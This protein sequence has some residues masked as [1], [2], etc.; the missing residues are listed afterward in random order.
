MLPL[1]LLLLAENPTYGTVYFKPVNDQADVPKEYRLNPFEFKYEMKLRHDYSSQGY[2]VFDVTFPTAILSN[3]EVNNTVHCQWY[4]PVGTGPFPATVILDILGGDQKL[5]KIQSAFLARKGI[6][7]LFVQ[8]A[9]YGPRRPP[10]TKVRL[11]MPNIEHTLA[12]V[13][14]TVLDIRLA[15]AWLAA[16]PEVDTDRIGVVG[17]SL[18]SFMGT[19]SAEMDPRFK[20]VAIVLG[21]GGLVDAFYDH[22]LGAPLR[23]LYQATGGSREKLEKIVSIADPLTRAGN[24]KD[25]QVLMIAA[26]K[27]EVVPPSAC[28]KMWEALG[29]PKI[30]WYDAGHYTAAF[31][32]YDA[33]QH[34]IEHLKK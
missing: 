16:R 26:S 33:L 8:M 9:Y 6:A 15:G 13:R 25:R 11:L 31:F 4:R 17:T 12:A 19:L 28:K 23:L 1:L 22:P 21:G 20:K 18:G 34:V 2:Q 7:C 10:G 27:D 32:I 30:V 14:Q 24:L 5:S 29:Q 3:Y